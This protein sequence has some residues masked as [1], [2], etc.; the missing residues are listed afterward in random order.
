MENKTK[1]LQAFARETGLTI[2]QGKIAIEQKLNN[3]LFAEVKGKRTILSL[4]GDRFV[5]RYN[6]TKLFV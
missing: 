2:Q 4:E 6:G 1:A 3:G 5:L